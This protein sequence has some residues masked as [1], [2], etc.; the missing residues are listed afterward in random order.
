MAGFLD[1]TAAILHIVASSPLLNWTYADQ[2]FQTQSDYEV[3]VG[4]TSG[5]SDMWAPGPVAGASTSVPYAGFPLT[6]GQDYYFGVRVRDG[7]DWGN[8]TVVLFH[9]NTP[10][11]APV[12]QLPTDGDLTVIYGS[13][14][15]DWDPVAD[16]DGDTGITYTWEVVT[17]PFPATLYDSGSGTATSDTVFTSPSTT[18]YWR[19]KANDGWEDGAYSTVFSFRTTAAPIVTG[20]LNVTVSGPG[21]VLSGATVRLSVSGVEIFNGTTNA[22]GIVRFPIL[23]LAVPI[24]VTVTLTGYRGG[25]QTVTLTATDPFGDVAITLATA[26][27]G[28]QPPGEF[29]WWILALI[30]VVIAV[31]LILFLLLRRRKPKEEMAVAPATLPMAA[32]MPAPMAPGPGEAPASPPEA[33]TPAGPPPDASA[34]FAEA[35]QKLTRLQT[36]KDQGLISEAEFEARRKELLG[37]R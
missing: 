10:P 28:G 30:A 24:T 6:D 16:A 9:T 21:G 12:L 37:A 23:P 19:V 32:E 27:G 4:N 29:P 11:P 31:L 25:T 5:A 20:S 2:D 13:V 15:L 7:V 26:P 8:W 17:S 22:N 14:P 33:P 18:Y 1:G 3:R 35:A 36:L 34:P